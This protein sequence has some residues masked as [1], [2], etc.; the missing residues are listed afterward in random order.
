MHLK[1]SYLVIGI[2]ILPSDHF[3]R[4]PIITKQAESIALGIK[5]AIVLTEKVMHLQRDGHQ[6]RGLQ[7]IKKESL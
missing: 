6:W 4:L 7:K 3:L 1:E 2:N 5:Q